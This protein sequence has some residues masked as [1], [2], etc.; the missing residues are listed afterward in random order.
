MCHSHSVMLDSDSRIAINFAT[1]KFL[2]E[3][4]LE[5]ESESRKPKGTGIG[6]LNFLGI[7]TGR[8]IKTYLGLDNCV[9]AVHVYHAYSHNRTIIISFPQ[10]NINPNLPGI[11]MGSIAMVAGFIVFLLPET[12]GKPLPDTIAEV[13]GQTSKNNDKQFKL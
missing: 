9:Y 1:T 5:L 11:L 13:E 12:T 8:G 6:L 7:R 3:L 10:N 2:L 4:E